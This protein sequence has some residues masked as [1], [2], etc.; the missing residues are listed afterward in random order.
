[1]DAELEDHDRT[2]D[3]GLNGEQFK[4]DD[5]EHEKLIVDTEEDEAK[6]V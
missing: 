5:V 6:P 3:L 2:T 1:M 4:Y